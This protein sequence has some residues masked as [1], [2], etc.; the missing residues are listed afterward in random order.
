MIRR[1]SV[2]VV[3]FSATLCMHKHETKDIREREN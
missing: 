2:E 3:D 1:R